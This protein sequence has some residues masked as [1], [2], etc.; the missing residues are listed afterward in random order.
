MTKILLVEDDKSLREIYSVR[1]LAEGYTLISCG[2]GE[3]ALAAAIGEK[4]D[5]IISDVMMPKISGFEMLDLLRSNEATKNIKVIMLTALSSEQ[6]RERGDRLGADR[7][8]IK[9]QVGIEDIVRTVH[10]VLGDGGQQKTLSQ[11]EN[12]TATANQSNVAPSQR[13]VAATPNVNN[14]NQQSVGVNP[15]VRPIQA[16]PTMAPVNRAPMADSPF[17]SILRNQSVTQSVPA[18]GQSAFNPLAATAPAAT[19]G[20]PAPKLPDTPMDIPARTTAQTPSPAT[21]ASA[22]QAADNLVNQSIHAS[23]AS[24]QPIAQRTSIEP[25]PTG[26]PQ[27]QAVPLPGPNGA[28]SV[29]PMQP[30][31]SAAQTM[32][33]YNQVPAASGQT[34]AGNATPTGS[35]PSIQPI[36]QQPIQSAPASPYNMTSPYN[37]ASGSS[38]NTTATGGSYIMGQ[39]APQPSLNQQY[40]Q[41]ETK[42]DQEKDRTAGGERVIKPLPGYSGSS[43]SPKINIDELLADSNYGSQSSSAFPQR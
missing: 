36:Q 42:Y 38:Q 6:Q 2:D 30:I 31:N 9:S 32:V 3:E 25:I 13:T 39:S 15:P 26:G 40:Q 1:L 16:A 35:A 21:Y 10:D 29:S 11:M 37:L 27:L 20:V 41:I 17:N 12:S 43:P 18:A 5:L 19:A 4:P 23:P 14:P 34:F 24:V 22:M 28:P 7:Y 33:Q 8:L